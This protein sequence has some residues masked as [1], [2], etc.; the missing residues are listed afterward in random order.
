MKTTSLKTIY[1]TADELKQ[2]IVEYLEKEH[3]ELAQHLYDNECEMVWGQDGKEFLV[4]IDG[5]ID[6]GGN[7]PERV[8]EQIE[9]LKKVAEQKEINKMVDQVE[10]AAVKAAHKVMEQ[11][12]EAFEKLAE[13]KKMK[14][15]E[16]EFDAVEHGLCVA[17]NEG[18]LDENVA[19][20]AFEKMKEVYRRYEWIVD[21][22]SA[23]IAEVDLNE[24]TEYQSLARSLKFI[25]Q[26][27]EM[28]NKND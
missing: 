21:K 12:S 1:L 16:N 4:S 25:N 2:A 22:V 27:S 13:D 18:M 28:V 11:H 15:T 6:D 5:E 7:T 24:V 14:I 3:E 9:W 19:Y 26:L 23:T 8:E 20:P 17:S 10:S